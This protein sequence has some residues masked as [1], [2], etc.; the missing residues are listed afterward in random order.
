MQGY[1]RTIQSQYACSPTINALAKAFYDLINPEPDINL[2]Y[3]NAFNLDTARGWGLDVWGQIVAIDRELG[4]VEQQTDYFGFQPETGVTNPRLDTYNNAPFYSDSLSSTFILEDEPYRLLIK[5]KAIANI[6]TG[7]LGD[8]NRIMHELIPDKT[9][10]I[11]HTGT[12]HLRILVRGH[13]ESYQSLL[14]NRGDLPPMPAGVGWDTY[15]VPY[16]T[17]GFAGQGLSNFDNATFLDT[18]PKQ[19]VDIES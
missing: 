6:S 18:R 9:I 13:L 19:N 11:L 14:L 12:M 2:F 8:L 4:Q 10:A 3:D 17:F 7:S 5:T 1:K 15:E 16:D